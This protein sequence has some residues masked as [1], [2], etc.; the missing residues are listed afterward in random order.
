MSSSD[1]VISS[2]KSQM[3]TAS[4]VIFETNLGKYNAIYNTI[5]AK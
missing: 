4:D 2:R 3:S 1:N 5:L